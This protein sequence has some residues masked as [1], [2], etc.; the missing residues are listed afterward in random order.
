MFMKKISI[1]SIVIISSL[2]LL[3]GCA[4]F[5][6]VKMP[7]QTLKDKNLSASAIFYSKS[8]FQ[9]R[10][11]GKE[12]VFQFVGGAVLRNSLLNYDKREGMRLNSGPFEK[13]LG[14]FD[15]TR[16]FGGQFKE[17]IGKSRILKIDLENNPERAG[18][19]A[20]FFSS[21]AKDGK[22]LGQKLKPG[23]YVAAFKI[24]YG[25]ACR[26]GSENIGFRKYYR[27][28][29]MLIGRVKRAGSNEA[30][31]Q[32][33]VIAFSNNRYLGS[34]ASADRIKKEELVLAF[35]QLTK[36]VIDMTVK[37]LNGEALPEMPPLQG[38]NNADLSF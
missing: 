15:V 1:L 36:E 24:S 37:S 10:F 32:E 26:P 34:D 3:G 7:E 35:K 25:L 14:D 16:Y 38:R 6:S 28:F 33:Y 4:S 30:V 31:W 9:E 18:Q 12:I 27:P 22:P 11:M 19:I 5:D 21:D 20:E 23:E 17:N 13:L 8:F 2:Y 29:I